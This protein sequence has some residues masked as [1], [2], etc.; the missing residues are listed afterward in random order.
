MLPKGPVQAGRLR[1][2]LSRS[3]T[4]MRRPCA[5]RSA[6]LPGL[7]II[8]WRIGNV[9]RRPNLI[10]RRFAPLRPLLYHCA[11]RKRRQSLLRKPKPDVGKLYRWFSVLGLIITVGLI[12]LL[13]YYK[14]RYTEEAFGLAQQLILGLTMGLYF[15][16]L[17][18]PGRGNMKRKDAKWLAIFM[19]VAAGILIIWGIIALPIAQHYLLDWEYFDDQTLLAISRIAFVQ[20][21]VGV[22]ALGAKGI[23]LLIPYIRQH[24]AYLSEL[25]SFGRIGKK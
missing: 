25:S 15:A 9:K 11:I 21:I 5:C 24:R 1:K 20:A 2:Q 3:W 23:A 4:L 14:V 16:I 18:V 6:P 10:K 22:L 19:L 7:P 13:I 17:I 8:E 12:P